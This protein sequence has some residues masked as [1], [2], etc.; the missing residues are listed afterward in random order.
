MSKKIHLPKL[1][2][3]FIQESKEL[4]YFIGLDSIQNITIA[5]LDDFNH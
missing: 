3:L 4:K 1:K 2:K 5:S